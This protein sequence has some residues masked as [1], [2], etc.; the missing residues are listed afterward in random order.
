MGLSQLIKCEHR[1][2]LSDEQKGR[3][4]LGGPFALDTSLNSRRFAR[5]FCRAVR[6]QKT[7]FLQKDPGID[8][9]QSLFMNDHRIQVHLLDVRIG[10][11]N[12]Q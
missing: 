8:D 6:F 3:S 10:L 2:I 7:F 12:L 4:L 9:A 1:Y 11:Y 5:C